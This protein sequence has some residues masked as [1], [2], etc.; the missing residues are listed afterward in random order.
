MELVLEDRTV[1]CERVGE[2][3]PLY[4]VHGGPGLDHS[5]FRPW[6]DPLST[7]AE[8]VF[9]DQHGCGRSS[10][11]ERWDFGL[12]GW[13][14]E[15]DALR[16]A[17]GHESIVLFGH[18]FGALLAVL[19]AL[20]FPEHIRGLVLCSGPSV[21][22]YDGVPWSAEQRASLQAFRDVSDET[23]RQRWLA[24]ASQYFHHYNPVIEYEM[25][26][27]A[28]YSARANNHGFQSLD[29]LDVRPHRAK[30]V[31]PTLVLMGRH[32][33]A[34]APEQT[35]KL[36]RDIPSARLHV[37]QESGHLPFIEENEEFL[38]VVRSFLA[39]L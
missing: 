24:S 22:D 6:L 5:H 37:F 28:R 15:I 39:T 31:T 7:S 2:G 35:L 27:R 4:V 8:V 16:R 3:R 14:D 30:L 23:F 1:Y 34:V 19:H 18:S 12:D 36:A 21:F 9:Y 29:G 33:A 11:P 26:S 13:V 38:E 17:L 25:D 20:R 10:R 32:D